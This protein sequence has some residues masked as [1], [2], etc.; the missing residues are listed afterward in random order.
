MNYVWDTLILAK[1]KNIDI[2]DI[3]FRLAEIYSPYL[4]LAM[5]CLNFE[6]SDEDKELEVNPY[7]R[8]GW[9]FEKMFLPDNLDYRELREEL[10]NCMLHYIYRIDIYSG[11]NAHEFKKVFIRKDI[12][13]GYFGDTN[14]DRWNYFK[15]DEK[16]SVLNQMI[17]LYETGSSIEV[18]R[19][20]VLAVFFD[21]FVY[22]NKVNK[23]EVLIFAGIRRREEYE[24][25]MQFIIDIFLPLDFNYRVYWAK[26]FGI[27]GREEVMH[28]D[29]I[30][31][32]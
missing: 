11:M 15:A 1:R 7:Y 14:K 20:A 26:H 30:V 5:S 6:L 8:F 23:N 12:E 25:K 9:I 22:Y 27:I 28:A 10:L 4:E 31:L 24:K 17:D 3:I 32:Y 16:D 13:S 29:S 18:L 2:K 21:G 19:K